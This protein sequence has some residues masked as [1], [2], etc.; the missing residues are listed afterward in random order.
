MVMSV[1]P[2]VCITLAFWLGRMGL[3]A[4]GGCCAK[5]WP[6]HPTPNRI[7]RWK[8]ESRLTEIMVALL[9]VEF[10][11]LSNATNTNGKSSSASV[12]DWRT[13]LQ[14]RNVTP[15][16]LGRIRFQMR[17]QQ[18]CA[19]GVTMLAPGEARRAWGHTTKP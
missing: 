8:S 9:V 13:G 6:A 3:I 4:S 1:T 2:I 17:G 16:T 15:V 11:A 7:T 12:A 19:A 5:A 10:G 14:D 18:A